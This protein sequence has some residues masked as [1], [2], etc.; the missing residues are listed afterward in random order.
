MKFWMFKARVMILSFLT[1]PPPD[2]HTTTSTNTHRPHGGHNFSQSNC[3]SNISLEVYCRLLQIWSAMSLPSYCIMGALGHPYTA[4]LWPVVIAYMDIFAWSFMSRIARSSECWHGTFLKAC[5]S[6]IYVKIYKQKLAAGRKVHF[7]ADAQMEFGQRP[8]HTNGGVITLQLLI[9]CPVQC[10]TLSTAASIKVS[11]GFSGVQS[12]G[13]F[14]LLQ[15]SAAF[16]TWPLLPSWNFLLLWFLGHCTTWFSSCFSVVFFTLDGFSSFSHIL[17]A[18]S[19]QDFGLWVSASLNHCNH[20]HQHSP[21]KSLFLDVL[22]QCHKFTMFKVKFFP[23]S[24]PFL[25]SFSLSWHH[26]YAV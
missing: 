10:F 19:P 1:T 23:A 20:S 12:A 16:N 7:L 15:Y 18:T 5:S 13:F 4:L 17:H 9:S 21:L 2:T 11:I 6:C 3:H 22:T 26:H 8:I 25:T 14:I 24:S